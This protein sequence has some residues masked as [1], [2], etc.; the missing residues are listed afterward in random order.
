MR[1]TSS[2]HA[3]P[4]GWPRLIGGSVLAGF[5]LGLISLMA[6]TLV[7]VVRTEGTGATSDLRADGASLWWCGEERQAGRRWATLSA[8]GMPLMDAPP[9]G[10]PS[11]LG[12]PHWLPWPADAD[13][14]R[15]IA[16]FQVGWPKPWIGMIWHRTVGGSGWPPFP[17]DDEN[18]AQIESASNRLLRLDSDG[19][20]FVDG[21]ALLVDI[22]FWTIAWAL[23]LLVMKWW[24]GAPSRIARI[25]IT[26]GQRSGT[27]R[28]EI[29]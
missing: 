10:G 2:E 18:G 21:K 1:R 16:G 5:V 3:G 17:Y 15:R 11:L 26:S 23:T 24:F 19:D 8:Y 6:V 9:A 14:F 20:W 28:R 22:V 7:L 25:M 4:S 12:P 27:N 29:E 13:E